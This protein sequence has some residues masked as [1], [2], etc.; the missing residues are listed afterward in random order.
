MRSDPFAALWPVVDALVA[1]DVPYCIGGSVASSAHGVA[2]AALDVDLVANLHRTHMDPLLDTLREDYFID[3]DAAVDAVRRRTMFQ[4]VHLET[5]LKVDVFVLKDD[6][7]DRTSFGRRSEVVLGDDEKRLFLATPEDTILHKLAR[8]RDGGQVSDQ[9]WN[10]VIGVL[11]VQSGRLDVAYMRSWVMEPRIATLLDHA[12]TESSYGLSRE[13]EDMSPAMQKLTERLIT[14]SSDEVAGVIDAVS[15]HGHLAIPFLQTLHGQQIGKVKAHRAAEAID[16]IRCREGNRPSP[17]VTWTEGER[18]AEVVE[19]MSRT[20]GQRVTTEEIAGDVRL[21]SSR[22]NLTLL[23]ALEH[24]C[25]DGNCSWRYIRRENG[26]IRLG[27]GSPPRHPA[28]YDGPFR[29]QVLQATTRIEND[30]DETR[31]AVHLEILA[32][33]EPRIMLLDRTMMVDMEATDDRGTEL[34]IRSENLELRVHQIGLGRVDRCIITGFAADATSIRQLRGRI[35]FRVATRSAPIE[36]A[37]P[38]AGS[39][40]KSKWLKMTVTNFN[41]EGVTVNE[42][43]WCSTGRLGSIGCADRVCC[44]STKS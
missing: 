7:F 15:V 23:E 16:V 34:Q 11:R 5:V 4:L 36:I 13:S 35:R 6:P 12:L 21:N 19:R 17:L 1:L 3:I 18:L 28:A 33:A 29:A 22:S 26:E 10:D 20:M 43:K 14:C 24:L 41:G 42:E 39:V 37:H 27:S 40:I 44:G 2:R 9:N 25:N 30:F 8:V 32:E 31:L 38:L